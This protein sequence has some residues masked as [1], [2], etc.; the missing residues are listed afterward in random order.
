MDFVG[1]K[2]KKQRKTL[3]CFGLKENNDY[4]RKAKKMGL[5]D[6]FRNFEFEESL[7]LLF[8]LVSTIYYFLFVFLMLF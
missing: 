8:S 2:K 1:E 3:Y 4:D 7:S 5:K 6:T